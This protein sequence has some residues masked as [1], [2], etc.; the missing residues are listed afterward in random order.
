MKNMDANERRE[1]ILDILK[2]QSKPISASSL[3]KCFCISR[4]IIVG[5]IALLRASGT[6][7]SSTARGYLL[8]NGSE[9][10]D[11]YGYV[12]ILACRHYD[13]QLLEELCCV[14]DY[15]GCLIDVLIE[16]PIY[17]QISGNLDVR[18]RYDAE[19]FA[20]RVKSG[21]GTPLSALTEGIHLHHIG[22]R[23]EAAFHRIE[24]ALLDKGILLSPTW[25]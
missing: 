18:S 2:G 24:Q 22:C 19:Q 21:E 4:Q 8:L 20:A 25:T 15:G 1:K 10:A 7:I 5:D 3:A 9:E 23:D 12:G 17:G 14:V 11:S 6:D 16:H 13:D